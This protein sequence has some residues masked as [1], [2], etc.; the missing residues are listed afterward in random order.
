MVKQVFEDC[1]QLRRQMANQ[2]LRDTTER[3]IQQHLKDTEMHGE[4]LLQAEALWLNYKKLPTPLRGLWR[5]W[6]RRR[7][8]LLELEERLEYSD[9]L[10]KTKS[11][12]YCLRREIETAFKMST[13]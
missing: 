12:N 3:L 1:E 8:A 10:P 2:I 4:E 6:L 7:D 5:D 13:T 9:S 11:V